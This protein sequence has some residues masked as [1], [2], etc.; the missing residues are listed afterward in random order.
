[1]PGDGQ[2]ETW[3]AL[4]GPDM[5]PQAWICPECATAEDWTDAEFTEAARRASGPD[6]GI[7]HRPGGQWVEL[8]SPVD[9]PPE[10]EAGAAPG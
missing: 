5:K 1:M 9:D 4:I 2:L 7:G 10:D 3:I 6:I 8:G